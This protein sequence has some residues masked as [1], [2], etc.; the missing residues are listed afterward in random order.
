MSDK[1]P[2]GKWQRMFH[3]FSSCPQINLEGGLQWFTV[4][5]TKPRTGQIWQCC[6]SMVKG[7][8]YRLWMHMT[9]TIHSYLIQTKQEGRSVERTS[10][11][12]TLTFDLNLPTFNRLIP[13][14]QEYDW[15]SLVTIRLSSVIVVCN[16][17][18]GWLTLHGG[19]VRLRPVRQHL[20]YSKFTA[21]SCHKI[22][23]TSC[24][25]WWSHRR[26]YGGFLSWLKKCLNFSHT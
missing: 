20:V 4:T 26:E 12:P 3:F 6:C 1:C 21:E 23:L 10:P 22:I 18:G 19:P 13:C 17:A 7:I 9:T 16:T 15:Q 24:S 5:H 14:G 2:C 11:P 25:H 8:Q